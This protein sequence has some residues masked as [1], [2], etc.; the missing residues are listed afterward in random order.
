MGQLGRFV[1]RLVN[2]FGIVLAFLVV[3]AGVGHG[4]ITPSY[5]AV[6]S[7]SDATYLDQG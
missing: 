4:Q 7:R 2:S 5:P 6:Q 3:A 1:R